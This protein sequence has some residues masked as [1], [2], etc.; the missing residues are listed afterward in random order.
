MSNI[1]KKIRDMEDKEKIKKMTGKTP[2]HRCPICH[3]FTLWVNDE[4]NKSQCLMCEMIRKEK[5]KS[6]S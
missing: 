1:Y 5:E 3:R 4:T 6:E 2:K